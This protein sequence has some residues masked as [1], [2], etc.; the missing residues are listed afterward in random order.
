MENQ[1]I[2]IL[3]FLALI[4]VAAITLAISAAR[5]QRRAASSLYH[6]FDEIDLTTPDLFT[7]KN[8]W[9]RRATP[10]PRWNADKRRYE[11]T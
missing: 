4:T 8:R 1:I 6:E 5:K 10:A 3:V 9:V 7:Q 11:N 2:T